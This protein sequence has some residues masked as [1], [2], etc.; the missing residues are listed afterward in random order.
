[1]HGAG[2]RTVE[3]ETDYADCTIKENCMLT[4]TD[5]AV[6]RFQKI[7]EEQNEKNTGIKIF[8]SE[9]GCCG[10]SLAMDVADESKDGDATIEINGLKIFVEK[11]AGD[12]LANATI[13]F[14]DDQGFTI[15]GMPRS[16]CCS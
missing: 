9:G 13:D 2:H 8:M 5:N 16:S 10:P 3:T 11:E 12:L 6:K 4:L 1:M 14:S 7:L 15:R